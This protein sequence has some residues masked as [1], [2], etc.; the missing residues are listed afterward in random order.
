MITII[1][2]LQGKNGRFVFD[3]GI[4]LLDS[5]HLPEN[6]RSSI[7][8]PLVN[9]S[10]LLFARHASIDKFY[11]VSAIASA[12]SVKAA[13][14]DFSALDRVFLDLKHLLMQLS[15]PILSW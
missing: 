10:G 2:S 6:L 7:S 1:Y 4:P 11:C 8:I 14:S 13:R 3:R 5:C 9:R 15:L 12:R